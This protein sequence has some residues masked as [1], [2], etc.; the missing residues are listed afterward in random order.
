MPRLKDL[1]GQNQ[2][3]C[4]TANTY[5][6]GRIFDSG[7]YKRKFVKTADDLRTELGFGIIA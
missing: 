3:H 6:K 5:R 7:R 4:L 1:Y 2:L